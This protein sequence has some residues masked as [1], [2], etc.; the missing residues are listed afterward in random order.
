M[1]P[2]PHAPPP[3]PL[4]PLCG[5]CAIEPNWCLGID[6]PPS[7]PPRPPLD[8][9]NL[10]T[11]E[12]LVRGI[13]VSIS[14]AASGTRL[15]LGAGSEVE[16][17]A[18]N[19]SLSSGLKHTRNLTGLYRH[20]P[21]SAGAV[22]VFIQGQEY[23]SRAHS[24][25]TEYGQTI[26]A[27]LRTRNAWVDRVRVRVAYQVT[28]SHGN[29]R[30]AQPSNVV[31]RITHNTLSQTRDFNCD[32]SGTQS[33]GRRYL[34][35]CSCT[36]LPSAWFEAANAG[37]ARVEVALRDAEDAVDVGIAAVRFL[38][39]HA[40]PSWW[41]AELRSTTV[42]SGLS[43]PT[44]V[45]SS[46]GVF[47]TLPVSPLH[48]GE[49][50]DVYMY[51]NT[52]SLSLSTWRVRLYFSSSTASY[53]SFTQSAHF[54][55]AT[56]S[57]SAGEVSWL[58]TGIKPTTTQA[59]VTGSAIYLLKIRMHVEGAVVAGTYS[60][61]ELKLYPHATELI[62]GAAFVQGAD[63][64]VFDG[65]D[66]VQALGEL[67][68]V[69]SSTEGIFAYQAG[70][71]MANLAP[72]TGAVS[73]YDLTIVQVGSDDRVAEETS[74]S[75]I[76]NCSSTEPS[77]LLALSGCR[78]VLYLNQTASKD[79]SRVSVHHSGF[80][81]SVRF[82]VYTPQSISLEIEDPTLNRFSAA[83]GDAISTCSSGGRSSYPYQRTRI[84]AFA[85]GLDATPLVSFTTQQ[86]SVAGVTSARHDIIEGRQAGQTTV[87]LGGL[88]GKEPAEAIEVSDTLVFASTLVAR[89]ITSASWV[90]AG[91][92]PSEY[93][94]GETFLAS[95]EVSSVMTAEGDSGRM[96]SRVVW[97]DG[98]G[99]DVGY[100]PVPTLEEMQVASSSSGVALT[101]PSG[102]ESF[103]QVG[104]AVGALREC[105]TAMTVNWTVCSVTVVSGELPLYLDLPDPL[106]VEVAIAQARLTPRDNDARLAPIDVPTSSAL[107]VL[108]DFDDGSQRTMSTDA[109]VTYSSPDPECALTDDADNIITIV[110]SATCASV[111]VVAT[112]QLGSFRFVVN[113]TRPVVY[114]DA[115]RLTFSGYPDTG[116]NRNLA[117]TTLGL[118]P[119]FTGVYFH[120]TAKAV[121]RLTDATEHT[122]TGQTSL[123][124]SDPLVVFV[125]SASS[126]RMQALSVGSSEIAASFGSRTVARSVLDVQDE[127][128]DEASVLAWEVP[129]VDANNLEMGSSVATRVQL[130]ME[131]GL[132]L[133]DL[134]GSTYDSWISFESLVSFESLQPGALQIASDGQLTLLDNHHGTVLLRAELSCEQTRS[135]DVYDDD[136]LY[137]NLK[138]AQ[139]DVDFG[140]L[141]GQQFAH[142]PGAGFLDVEVHV[143]PERGT[144]LKAFQIKL[145]P[146][147]A[148]MLSSASGASWIDQGTFSGIATQLDNPSTEVVLSAADTASTVASQITLGTIRL[149]VIGSGVSLIDGEIESLVVHDSSGAPTEVQYQAVVAGRGYVSLTAG[150]RRMLSGWPLTPVGQLAPRVAAVAAGTARRLQACD[151]CSRQVWGD[152]NGDCQ[153]LSSDVLALSEFV[154][155][156]E[157]FEDGLEASDPLQTYTANGA[158]CD[159]LRAQADPSQDLMN[160]AGDDTA[161]ARYGRPAVTGLDTQHLLYGTVKKHRFLT[162]MAASCNDSTVPG[163]VAQDLHV[164]LHLAGGDGQNAAPVDAD[165]AFTDVFLELRVSPAPSPFEFEIT[166][167]VR[168]A[169]KETLGGGLAVTASPQG[170]GWFEAR[171]QPTGGYASGNATYEIA[172]IVE[173]KTASG[174]K[175]VPAS[176]KAWLGTSMAPL[177][178]EYGVSYAPAWGGALSAISTQ[179]VTC[180]GWPSPP[181]PEPS[182]PPLLPSNAIYVVETSF[183]AAGD[184]SDFSVA[185]LRRAFA[186][187]AAVNVSQV[188]VSVSPASV[189]IE[190]RISTVSPTEAK[191]VTNALQTV[192]GNATSA[193]AT[194]N[195]QIESTPN[196]T[197]TSV[198][199]VPPSHPP[200]W[201]PPRLPSP[202]LPPASPLPQAP[203]ASLLPPATTPPPIS[204]PLLPTPSLPLSLT[205][206]LL[207]PPSTPSPLPQATRQPPPRPLPPHPSPPQL[208][209]T[210]RERFLLQFLIE[211]AMDTF[212]ATTFAVA[213]AGLLDGI[214]HSDIVLTVRA[215]SVC[216]TANI[217]APRTEV[218]EAARETLLALSLSQLSTKLN[219]TVLSVEELQ[220]VQRQALSTADTSGQSAML[221]AALIGVPMLLVFTVLFMLRKR[222]RAA[223]C[224][225]KEAG[226]RSHDVTIDFPPDM[227]SENG[228][229]VPPALVRA[230]SEQ[231]RRGA[232]VRQTAEQAELEMA[233]VEQ[234]GKEEVELARLAAEE[235]AA[236]DVAAEQA[237]VEQPMMV[238]AQA[239]ERIA[240]EMAAA[241]LRAALPPSPMMLSLPVHLETLELALRAGRRAGVAV[242]LLQRAELVVNA[243][244]LLDPPLVH[245]LEQ[246]ALVHPAL[247]AETLASDLM[248]RGLL[249]I[250]AVT[251]AAPSALGVG[252]EQLH[253]AA[254]QACADVHVPIHARRCHIPH[255]NENTPAHSIARVK[256]PLLACHPT[257]PPSRSY[258]R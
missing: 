20:S 252:G 59:Q 132:T 250:R 125:S 183:T 160:K 161:D 114:M 256:P 199:T 149:N 211:G 168:A 87:H 17:A 126:T 21:K 167:G 233:A 52:A 138:A 103:F 40:Q 164:V 79:G 197:T 84:R 95:V 225:Q 154:L 32:T 190:L 247:T 124:S 226:H 109:R 92:P 9:P 208:S 27:V 189:R 203:L 96:F 202:A 230:R 101:P 108:V 111:M 194:L 122:V 255:P 193:L 93:T 34:A 212:D 10:C 116:S 78:V 251:A 152:F 222:L 19:A 184:V 46:G 36:S 2:S 143:H 45:T 42:G 249:T 123:N 23:L 38:R 88:L 91:Q 214:T 65:R 151:P 156:R 221:T 18:A 179:A 128:R 180:M 227:E 97:S 12:G 130:T 218:V 157:R 54:N 181:P 72:L 186:E 216:I 155:S 35:H 53:V 207:S 172:V 178:T 188:E 205:A 4:H 48:A 121:A 170:G 49:N 73:E 174:S 191:E 147:D 62:S 198:S 105:S 67:K 232:A 15:V 28:D 37:N 94:F 77:T 146:L 162:A 257:L 50:F 231:A 142:T 112:A 177:G 240:A 134:A 68:V 69:S 70:G 1:S 153:F 175:D 3:A 165:P 113:H 16:E 242:E 102:G 58:A 229:R 55:S 86:A 47:V 235:A 29:V 57:E 43:A 224:M 166:Q 110:P 209:H 144:S 217:T 192:L 51:A 244:R 6:C 238:R 98:Y 254:L 85:D 169:S 22:G 26:T 63:G 30:V 223:L 140:S 60:G 71:T 90:A 135:F 220:P 99:E 137:A 171:L 133:A 159:F 129:R 136:T 64:Q 150:R 118:V 82:D 8:P 39:I 145:G 89:V 206:P 195:L 117:V 239:E 13:D 201:P 120:A 83:N 241:E 14:A 215:A 131:S 76:Q 75:D 100:D 106:R 228:P 25:P 115:L 237:A 243:N 31:L 163:S 80:N 187:L 246:L 139:M 74:V 7:P 236:E 185:E 204:P 127:P 104:V 200:M 253:T 182:P 234:D 173:T 219:F 245:V 176:Y 11:P 148:D 33:S 81:T 66:G 210:P 213:L 107:R 196:F 41:D 56:S 248:Q 119:C 61:S 258:T 141:S 5:F 24:V 44:G 158:D